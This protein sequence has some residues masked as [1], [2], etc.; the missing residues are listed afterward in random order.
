MAP[1]LGIFEG[2]LLTFSGNQK[3]PAQSTLNP[4]LDFA[5]GRYRQVL[6]H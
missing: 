4:G 5:R 1:V 2:L 3:C 6:K